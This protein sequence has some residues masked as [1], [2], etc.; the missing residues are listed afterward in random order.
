MLGGSTV[1]SLGRARRYNV[2][3]A[4]YCIGGDLFS[5]YDWGHYY[6]QYSLHSICE[7]KSLVSTPEHIIVYKCPALVGFEEVTTKC[8]AK[9]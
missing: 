5:A 3:L 9:F 8:K 1:R 7:V 2:T 4:R 6:L